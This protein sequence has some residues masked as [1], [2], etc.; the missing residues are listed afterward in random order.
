MGKYIVRNP[1]R[2]A[3]GAALALTASAALAHPGHH[4]E[5]DDD[6]DD[7]GSGRRAIASVLEVVPRYVE[8][9]VGRPEQRCWT[10]RVRY[11]DD[12]ERRVG[13]TIL[14]SLIGGVLGHNL[15]D[16]EARGFGTAAG[17]VVGGLIGHEVAAGEA[18]ERYD[19]GRRATLRDVQRCEV[20]ARP[21]FEQ[22]VA[23]YDVLYEYQGR[24]YRTRLPY[25]PGPTLELD[26]ASAP[27]WR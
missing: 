7:Q 3:L 12:S 5:R 20:I 18:D 14:G 21:E 25:D 10:E 24:R 4:W 27:T 13:G 15:V 16:G 9:R 6:D 8:V 26:R 23:D 17:A 2:L 19:R 11:G 22:R 1:L